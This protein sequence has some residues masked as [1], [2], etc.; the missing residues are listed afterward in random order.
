MQAILP[1]A[2]AS[3]ATLWTGRILSGLVVVFLLFDGAIKVAEM[4]VVKQ[5]LAELGYPAD[6]AF[7]LGVLTLAIGALYAIPRTSLLGAILLTGLLGGAMATHLRVGSPV[8]SHL[9]F[10]LYIGLMAWG[11]LFLRDERLRAM[12]PLRR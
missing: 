8:F 9:L 2:P 7:G 3:G 11:G 4:D 6:I 5:T 1:T 10:G 12:L